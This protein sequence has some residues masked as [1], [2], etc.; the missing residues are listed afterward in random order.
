MST[1][2]KTWMEPAVD[3]KIYKIKTI[4]IATFVGGPLVAGYLIAQNYRV[5]DEAGKAKMAWVYAVVTTF[6]IIGSVFLIPDTVKIPQ[7]IIPLIYSWLTYLL[8]K[9]FQADQI[10]AHFTAGGQAFTIWRALLI[11]LIGAAVT[12]A[13]VFIILLILPE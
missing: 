1:P 7:I 12:L 10:K 4:Q 6:V 13:L 5:F 8:V 2:D 3:Q 9:H 11:A